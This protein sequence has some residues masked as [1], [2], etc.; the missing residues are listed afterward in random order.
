MTPPLVI[1]IPDPSL[2]VLVGAAGSGKST[3]ASRHFAPEEI[4]SSDAFR[5]HITGDPGDQSATRA[6]FSAL[7]AALARRLAQGRLTVVDATSVKRAARLALL[8]RAAAAVVPAVA[9]VL[10]LPADAVHERNRR[11]PGR[12]VPDDAV[13]RQLAELAASLRPGGLEA[14]GFASIVRLADTGAV[15]AVVVRRLPRV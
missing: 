4:L 1:D 9:I 12:V 13:E 11:R 10:D 2:V 15:E 6:A 14:E 7:H 5:A 8:Q 3:F